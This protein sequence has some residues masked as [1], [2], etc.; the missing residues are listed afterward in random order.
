[1]FLV[2]PSL[3]LMK[4]IALRM[5]VTKPSAKACSEGHLRDMPLAGAD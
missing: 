2:L 3:F 4:K 5:A 1:M